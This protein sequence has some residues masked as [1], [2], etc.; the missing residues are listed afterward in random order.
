MWRYCIIGDEMGRKRSGSEL[1][2]FDLLLPGSTIE[3]IEDIAK[4][5]A[6]PPRTLA[7][8]LMVKTVRDLVATL[9]AEGG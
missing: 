4:R 3:A 5:E 2:R 1:T 9:V 7:R 6:I 8:S